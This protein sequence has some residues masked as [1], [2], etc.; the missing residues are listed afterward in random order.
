[1]SSGPTPKSLTRSSVDQR[2]YGAYYRRRS[3]LATDGIADC[4]MNRPPLTLFSGSPVLKYQ[5]TGK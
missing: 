5:S 2:Y 3:E 4:L 1:M